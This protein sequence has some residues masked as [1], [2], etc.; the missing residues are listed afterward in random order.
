MPDTSPVGVGVIGAGQ[1]G[2]NLVR[3]LAQ[4]PDA[5]L[6]WVCDAA[7]TTRDAVRAQYP[8]VGVTT[9]ADAL[10][11]DERV[12]AVVV[13]ASATTHA[14]LATR[15]LQAGKHVFVEKPLALSAADAEALVELADRK[16]RRLMVGHLLLYHQAVLDLERMVK[17]GELGEIH[18]LYSQRVNL[19]T[20]RRD[21]NALW[22]FAPHDLS[23]LLYLLDARPKSVSARGAAYIRP[24]VHD[25]VFVNVSFEN[26]AMGHLQVSWLDPHKVRKITVV[27]SKKMAVFDDMENSEKLRVYDKGV[28]PPAYDTYGEALA[29]RFGDIVIPQVRMTEPLRA[30]CLHFLQCVRSGDT[31]RSDGR[32]GLAVVKLLEAAQQSLERDGEP[33]AVS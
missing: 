22:S 3:V 28:E 2:R 8:E 26:G 24:N 25:V 14:A 32:S 13:S 1:W 15:A 10:L 12:Q 19:G 17:A 16:D 31:P 18:Y 30:E 4:L 33:V 29:L 11:A 6:H 20:I 21:E 5:A 23:V 27:G 7:E 9:D